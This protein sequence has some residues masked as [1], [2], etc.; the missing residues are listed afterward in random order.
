A[1]GKV[2]GVAYCGVTQ[3]SVPSLRKAIKDTKVGTSG[4]AMVL[5]GKGDKQGQV[6]I[7]PDNALDGKSLYDAK[8]ADGRSYVKEIV[9]KA[10]TLAPNEIGSVTYRLKEGREAQTVV[11]HFTYYKPWD[12]IL[13]VNGYKKDFVAL[14]NKLQDGRSGM[15]ETILAI[16]LLVALLSGVAFWLLAKSITGPVFQ[17]VTAAESI[18]SGDLT[19]VTLRQGKDEIGTL[20]RAFGRMQEYLS[21]VASTARRVADGD[22]GADFV[23]RGKKDALGQALVDMLCSLRQLV[24]HVVVRAR[25]TAGTSERLS[26]ASAEVAGVAS[27]IAD[28]MQEIQGGA[29]EAAIRSGEIADGN[30]RL[31]ATA[32]AATQ[33]MQE[34]ESGIKDVRA[35]S[36]RQQDATDAAAIVAAKGGQAVKNAMESMDRIQERV[37]ASSSAV[38]ELGAKQDQIGSIVDVI[39]E[40]AEQTNLLA[41]NAAI[42]AAR[43]GDS[44][45]G[46]AVVAD[47]VRKL[48]ERSADATKQIQGL[49]D[50]IRADVM[51]A[52]QAMEDSLREVSDGASFSV[53]AREALS[54]IVSSV[55]TVSGLA[56]AN[57]AIVQN[58]VTTTAKVADVIQSVAA[59]SEQTAAAAD[60][61]GM[62]SKHM[63]DSTAQVSRSV[64]GQANTIKSLSKMAEEL[65]GEAEELTLMVAR[66]RLEEQAVLDKAA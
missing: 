37:V 22:L 42:E 6:M 25:E 27:D 14:G 56:K 11:A 36:H 1:S 23:P 45:R 30:S 28:A 4:Y 2:I 35:G 47:E 31:A 5:G 53:A 51:D 43:A 15:A 13:V 66:F 9:D 57:D 20:S 65:R 49:I 55:D 46:F 39:G 44:G 17:M 40:I 50:T 16:G 64:Q 34:L 12:W 33:S 18:A 10:L 59:T 52:T 48:A 19:A 62:A 41:L 32:T 24:G 58:V 7:S 3:E 63:S 38:K 29:K 61:V 21:D 60:E 54:D 26:G 8:D